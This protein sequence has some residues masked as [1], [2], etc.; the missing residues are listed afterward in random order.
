MDN[1]Y[2]HL[3]YPTLVL[4]GKM[5]QK[6]ASPAIVRVSSPTVLRKDLFATGGSKPHGTLE[7]VIDP[8]LE[9]S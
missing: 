7:R 3:M 6:H 5:N 9:A 4:N 1:I 8:P 2:E